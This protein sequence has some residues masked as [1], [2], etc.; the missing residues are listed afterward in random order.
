MNA[1]F[2]S[3]K[4]RKSLLSLADMATTLCRFGGEITIFCAI[5]GR[6]AMNL[7]PSISWTGSKWQKR[8]K[9]SGERSGDIKTSACNTLISLSFLR[10]HPP[11]GTH[12]P[13]PPSKAQHP[14]GGGAHYMAHKNW[15]FFHFPNIKGLA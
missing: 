3:P 2:P 11:I 6:L 12:H 15:A 10:A 13:H 14:A 5:Y 4:A 1:N 8:L 7:Q 9:R